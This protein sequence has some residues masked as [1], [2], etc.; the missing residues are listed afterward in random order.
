MDEKKQKERRISCKNIAY[1]GKSAV[2][3]T[4]DRVCLKEKCYRSTP[5]RD[6]DGLRLTTAQIELK[7]PELSLIFSTV[8]YPNWFTPPS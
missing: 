7:K 2:L 8:I 1:T 3:I 5:P 6:I 4:F